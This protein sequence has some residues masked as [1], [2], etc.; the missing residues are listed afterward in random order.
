MDGPHVLAVDSIDRVVA[1]KSP[2]AYLLGSRDKEIRYVG[3]SDDDIASRPKAWAYSS[4]WNFWFD[5]ADSPKSAFEVECTQWHRH[6]GADGK[7]DN[8][9]HPA[10]PAASDWKCPDC[11]IFG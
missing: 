3:R 10:R 8:K 1:R 7:L 11:P 9:N 6:G 4:Y 2:G 5:Y